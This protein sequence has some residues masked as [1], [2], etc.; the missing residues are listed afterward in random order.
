MSVRGFQ[1]DRAI[2]LVGLMGAG[3]STLAP[4][5]ASRLNLDFIDTDREIERLMGLTVAEIFKQHGEAFFREKEQEVVGALD[6]STPS[7]VAT[8]G[9]VF[10][11]DGLRDK[12]LAQCITIWIDSPLPLLARRA[13]NGPTRPY[14]SKGDPAVALEHLAHERQAFYAMADLHIEN[15]DER[16][17]DVAEAILVA[18]RKRA[19]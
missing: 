6:L 15:G 11:N 5:L 18:L 1:I 3:K 16:P 14:L 12:L 13:G 19:S 7:V 17:A 10:A 9:G 4:V 8:G 2:A